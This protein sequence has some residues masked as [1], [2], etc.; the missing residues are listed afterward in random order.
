MR[1]RKLRQMM[2][3]LNYQAL[4]L[5]EPLNIRYLSGFSGS[6]ASLLITAQQQFLITDYRYTEQAHR[7]WASCQTRRPK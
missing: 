6:S 3:Q 5:T 2:A 1:L 7:A 4:L